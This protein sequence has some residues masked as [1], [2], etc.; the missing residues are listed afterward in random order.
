MEIEVELSEMEAVEMIES[1][2]VKTKLMTNL[3]MDER[4]AI[5][6]QA[7]RVLVSHLITGEQTAVV[8]LIQIEME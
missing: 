8:T 4:H 6:I 1:Q 5:E 2:I 3:V 7:I